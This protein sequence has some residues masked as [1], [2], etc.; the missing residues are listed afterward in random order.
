L[1]GGGGKKRESGGKGGSS[2]SGKEP[3][4]GETRDGTENQKRVGT[5]RGN[6][7][8]EERNPAWNVSSVKNGQERKG[9]DD[10]KR[11]GAIHL[12]SGEW[13]RVS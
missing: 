7:L 6:F 8:L 13:S 5:K 9:K 3:I 11:W 10:G 1:F 4:G 12:S 2:T